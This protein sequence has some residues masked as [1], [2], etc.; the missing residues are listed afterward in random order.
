MVLFLAC[1]DPKLEYERIQASSPSRHG[2]KEREKSARE[3]REST[4]M[5][6]ERESG[7][8]RRIRRRP[9]LSQKDRKALLRSLSYGGSFLTFR[10]CRVRRRTSAFLS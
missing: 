4:R 5:S 1:S 10:L 9:W 3:S 7:G 8:Q 2:L 6:R